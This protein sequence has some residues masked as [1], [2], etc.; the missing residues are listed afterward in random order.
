[1]QRKGKPAEK[2]GRKVT[3]LRGTGWSNPTRILR[4]LDLL[5]LS[6]FNKHNEKPRYGEHL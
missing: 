3:D 5:L 4:W 1:M 2:L 6:G